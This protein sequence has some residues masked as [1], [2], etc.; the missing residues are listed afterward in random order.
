VRISEA[1]ITGA[2]REISV[3]RGFHPKDF[4]LL[5]FGGGGGFVAASVA[6]E[7]GIP[8]TI[9]PPGPANFSALGMLMVDVVHD[10]A[11]TCVTDLAH[12]DVAMLNSIYAQ[13]SARGHDAL[14]RDGFAH[15]D[16]LVMY[17]AELRYQG[18]E[19]TVDVAIPGHILTANDLTRIISDFN[20]A[21]QT[22]YG[23]RMDD[24]VELVT[25]RLR[26]V[27]LLPRPFLPTVAA[28]TGNATKARKGSRLVYQALSDRYVDYAVYDRSRLQFRDRVEG[29]A[30]I[31]EPTCTTIVHAGDV[32]TV[33]EYG[34]LVIEIGK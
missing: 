6:R 33:G 5:A 1:K 3:E 22:Q 11:Q 34:E 17:S 16:C 31:E 30:I 10:F 8:K 20:E 27:G 7:L 29:P 9:I 26:A 23:H 14:T 19:H 4:A 28:G 15:K 12:A 13:L 2:L 32:M 25:V 18:Q 21:H 24:P